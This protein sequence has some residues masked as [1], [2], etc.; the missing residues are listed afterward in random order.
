EKMLKAEIIPSNEPTSAF[1]NPILSWPPVPRFLNKLSYKLNE[2]SLKMWTKP[3]REFR[4]N[5]GL[6]L[7][8]G[9]P[10][11]STIYSISE[12]LLPKPIDYPINNYYICL[13]T[14]NFSS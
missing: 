14:L 13:S 8:F 3:I 9:K 6:P 2:L 12:L 1:A 11:L 5:A 4:Q 10:D 7:K